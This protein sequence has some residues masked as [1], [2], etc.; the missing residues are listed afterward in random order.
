[1]CI[2]HHYDVM[3]KNPYCWFLIIITS[4]SNAFMP[5]EAYCPKLCFK[6]MGRHCII[7]KETEK[8]MH[9]FQA[10]MVVLVA[11]LYFFWLCQVV[12]LKSI[13]TEDASYF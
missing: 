7:S 6:T 8:E 11:F 3:E 13:S 5:K 9:V 10:Y 4:Y 2:I 1:M 12:T